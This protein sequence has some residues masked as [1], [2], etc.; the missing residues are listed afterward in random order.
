MQSGRCKTSVRTFCQR[1][2]P[3]RSELN[4]LR[5]AKLA[6]LPN[7]VTWG[8]TDTYNPC[9][10]KKVYTCEGDGSTLIQFLEILS[11]WEIA[12]RW[13]GIDP[14]ETD[15][16]KV[17]REVKET[18]REL[19]LNARTVPC[20]NTARTPRASA[21]N[22]ARYVKMGTKFGAVLAW[23]WLPDR[24]KSGHHWLIKVALV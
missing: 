8:P 20:V 3:V 2:S 14:D 16:G 11:V 5:R 24:G 6:T 13:H 17:A 12:Y 23:N 18:L 7:D 1:F 4:A 9:W 21:T 22:S 10:V 15:Q 19:M